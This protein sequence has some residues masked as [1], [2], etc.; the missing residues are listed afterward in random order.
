MFNGENGDLAKWAG[1]AATFFSACVAVI[2]GTWKNL[3]GRMRAL[4][5]KVDAKADEAE[6]I[7]QRDHV[8]ELFEEQKSI[9]REM[10]EG[11]RGMQDTIHDLHVDL[12]EKF[13]ERRRAP[14]KQGGAAFIDWLI[15]FACAVGVIAAVLIVIALMQPARA[16]EPEAPVV[17]A[18]K[19][20]EAAED[21]E[22]DRIVEKL[23]QVYEFCK[24]QACE[25]IPRSHYDAMQR[26]MEEL[27]RQ[28]Y[29]LEK[30]RPAQAGCA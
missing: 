21:A 6:L 4:A 27:R 12:L 15:G 29:E 11:F 16:Q 14:R 22:I 18:P 20:S 3:N 8:V 28:L 23:R 2:L 19:L 5:L 25:V 13:S 7:R 1:A 24:Y 30:S 10:N 26:D 9:R 17:V